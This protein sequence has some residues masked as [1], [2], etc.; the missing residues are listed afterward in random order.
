MCVRVYIQI[1]MDVRMSDILKLE[2]WAVRWPML[3]AGDKTIVLC[4]RTAEP[5]FHNPFI[6]RALTDPQ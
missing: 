2:V 4:K 3:S 1:Y 6:S 5:L